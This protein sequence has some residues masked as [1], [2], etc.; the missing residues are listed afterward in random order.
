MLIT[1]F[2]TMNDATKAIRELLNERL[3]A[4]ANII[5]AIKSLYWWN[6]QITEEQEVIVFMKTRKE[7]EKKAMEKLESIHPYEVPAIYAIESTKEITTPYLQW[8]FNETKS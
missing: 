7:L 1:T 2:Q 6:D 8:I 3:I 4:C 5:P